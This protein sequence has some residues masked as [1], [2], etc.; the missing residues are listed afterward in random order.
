VVIETAVVP[1][2]VTPD[3][4]SGELVA[5][6]ENSR[7][8]NST[9]P[10]DGKVT[11]TDVIDAEFGLD[12]I[13]ARCVCD[14]VASGDAASRVHVCDAESVT[15]AGVADAVASLVRRFRTSRFPD[16]FVNVRVKV[17]AAVVVE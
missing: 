14:D 10:V 2:V 5:I 4:S 3:V 11:V 15:V 12:H 6:P 9:E 17:V 16:V 8:S 1:T 13:S 7:T